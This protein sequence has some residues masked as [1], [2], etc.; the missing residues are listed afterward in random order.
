MRAGRVQ[1][2]AAL[3]VRSSKAIS[4]HGMTRLRTMDG[5]ADAKD[6]CATV[7]QLTGANSCPTVPLSNL[8]VTTPSLILLDQFAFP[9]I[10]P[11]LPRLSVSSVSTPICFSPSHMSYIY[12]P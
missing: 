6:V 1:E 7:R 8:P 3:S 10:A 12:F 11:Q 9:Q 4:Q 5:K 2:V